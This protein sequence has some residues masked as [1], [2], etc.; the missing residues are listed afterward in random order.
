MDR[1]PGV[2]EIFAFVNCNVK[3]FAPTSLTSGGN[4]GR[5]RLYLCSAGDVTGSYF[6]PGCHGNHQASA[7]VSGSIYNLLI[8]FHLSD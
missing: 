3:V 5:M 4:G 8:L 7:P 6:Q 1:Y 2:A